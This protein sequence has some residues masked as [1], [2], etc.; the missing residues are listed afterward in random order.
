MRMKLGNVYK[1]KVTGY[2]GT[3]T[4]HCEYLSGK[5]RTMLERSGDAEEK[6]FTDERLEPVEPAPAA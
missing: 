5:P 1:D 4:V 6:W 3:A 2:T